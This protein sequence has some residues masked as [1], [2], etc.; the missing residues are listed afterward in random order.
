MSN[1]TYRR[2]RTCALIYASTALLII[3]TPA[4]TQIDNYPL[5][6]IKIILPV[7]VGG[8]SDRVL[9]I[10]GKSL[11]DQ[12]SQPF[13]IEAKPGATGALGAEAVAKSAADGYTALFAS[14]TFIQAPSL[15]PK[16]PYDYVKDFTPVSLTTRVTVVFVVSTESPIHS[17]QDYLAA[18]ASDKPATYG[19]VGLGSS[20]H[21]YGETLARDS[22]AAMVHVPYR[23]EQGIISDLIGGHLDSSFLSITS[24]IELIRAGKLR[25]LGV[26]GFTRSPLL[27]DVPTFAEL[28]YDRLDL[29]GWF[30][31]LMPAGTPHPVVAKMSLGIHD[32]LLEPSIN[33]AIVEMGLEP[34]GSTPEEFTAVIGRDYL[35][36]RQLIKEIA[37]IP[38]AQ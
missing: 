6:P 3:S 23:G 14:T 13:V 30:G 15:L 34:I 9:R 29:L 2:C 1:L 4:F 38:E 33:S 24:T 18:A 7:A 25:P 27:A 17:L 21:I 31:M 26:I 8:A 37:V 36:W 5:R 28:G 20:L 35:R 16:V 11:T 19:S 32:V 10:I 12:W 22:K